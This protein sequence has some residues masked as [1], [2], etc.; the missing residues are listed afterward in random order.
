MAANTDEREPVA[1]SE[2]TKAEEK[3]ETATIV[4][5]TEAAKNKDPELAGAEFRNILF[6]YVDRGSRC[7]WALDQRTSISRQPKPRKSRTVFT[8]SEKNGL[9]SLSL[10]L[11]GFLGE[12][13]QYVCTRVH[14]LMQ[15]TVL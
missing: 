15:Q 2:Q 9:S 8:L 3:R 1:V 5:D 14:M 6:E 12:S 11:L 13:A 7:I 10:P 4:G